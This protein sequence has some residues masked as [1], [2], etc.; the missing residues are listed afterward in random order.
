M[1]L[2]FMW[3][4][5]H[6]VASTVL[7]VL[8]PFIG[9]QLHGDKECPFSG[10]TNSGSL[11]EGARK[12]CPECAY[13]AGHW[14]LISACRIEARK[15]RVETIRPVMTRRRSEDQWR[16]MK[17]YDQKGRYQKKSEFPCFSLPVLMAVKLLF[18]LIL[19]MHLPV[20]GACASVEILRVVRWGGIRYSVTLLQW[21]PEVYFYTVH[22]CFIVMLTLGN[23]VSVQKVCEYSGK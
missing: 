1:R 11:E 6:Y 19:F 9:G 21:L 5:G 17:S 22:W 3:V 23:T 4:L 18:G 14:G 15:H 7:L 16:K 2:M 10:I 13:A 20:F 8:K 12:W